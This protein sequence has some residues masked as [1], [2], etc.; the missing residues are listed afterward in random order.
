VLG[1]AAN[2]SWTFDPGAVVLL[3]IVGGAYSARWRTVR[4]AEGARGAPAGRAVL[5]GCGLLAMV[6]ALISPVDELGHQLLTMHMV[7]HL[8]LLDVGPILMVLGLTK[9][10]LRPV[11]RRLAIVERDWPL[12]LHPAFAVIAY[13]GVMAVW[14]VPAMYD[15]AVRHDLIHA[16]EHTCFF[17]AGALYWWHLLSPIRSPMRGGP[18]GPVVYMLVTKLFV[19]LLGILITFAPHAIYGFYEHVPRVWGLSAHDDQALAGAIMAVEQ[20]LIMGIA[21]AYLFIKALSESD[22]ADERA[23]RYGDA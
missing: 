1:A 23:E 20:S 6:V 22:L 7:Q 19:G 8:L 5:F 10:L 18:F 15:A 11:T 9:M 4:A 17:T 12:L 21:L 13:V 2:T 14:H 16:L 3:L